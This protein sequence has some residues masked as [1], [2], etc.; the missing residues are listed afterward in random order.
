MMALVDDEVREPEE[1]RDAIGAIRAREGKRVAWLVGRGAE[2]RVAR[3][4]NYESLKSPRF[5]RANKA[6][7]NLRILP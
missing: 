6:K 1:R 4:S 5:G 2:S 7:T 3:L